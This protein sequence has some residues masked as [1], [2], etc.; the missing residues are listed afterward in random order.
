MVKFDDKDPEKVL[1]AFGWH[2]LE[3]PKPEDMVY[4]ITGN[5]SQVLTVK[6]SHGNM[7]RG[8]PGTMF[9]L[10]EG[11]HQSV[12]CDQCFERC[13]TGE[14]CCTVNFSNDG[15][16][17]R[18]AYAALTPNFPTAK[19][20]PVDLS[21]PHVGG[22]LIAQRGAYMASYGDVG[23]NISCDC[24]FML[25]CCG[26]MGLVRQK[27]VGS[28]TVFLSSTGTMVQ[29]VLAPGETILVDTH[30]LMAFAGSCKMDLRQAGNVLGMVGGGEG[31]FNTTVTGPGLVIVQ[32]MNEIMFLQSLVPKVWRR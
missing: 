5:E 23:V 27:L 17:G 10:S 12:S 31:I 26:G 25:C 19:V 8:E 7:V 18:D 14:S 3:I 4:A 30:C 6:L 15:S 21:S 24:N 2:A 22:T 9:Y 11:I 1:H 16:S 28:G 13:C 20:V 32:S 29:K